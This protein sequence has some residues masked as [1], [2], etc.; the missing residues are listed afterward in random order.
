M[1][2]H[3]AV[4]PSILETDAATVLKRIG[5]LPARCSLVEIR[6]DSLSSDDL[7][8][9]VARCGRDAVVTIRTKQEGGSFIGSES[10]RLDLLMAGLHT[11]A[12]YVD[13]P[14]DSP[15]AVQGLVPRER[16]ILS[17]HGNHREHGPLSTILS[18]MTSIGAALYKMVPLAMGVECLQEI[19]EFL[20]EVP[21]GG[22][23]VICF[24]A[25]RY[26]A[27]SRILAPSWGSR[28]TF[29]F[30]PGGRPTAEGQFPAADLL[31]IYNVPAIGGQ[32][33]IFGLL[34]RDLAGSPSPAM[35]NAA[36]RDLG[37]DARYLPM[38]V[39]S[40]RDFELLSDPDG[41]VGAEGFGVTMPFKGEAAARCT[42]LD[43]WSTAA[44]AVN[45]LV[46]A[47]DGWH[48]RNSDAMAI[49]MLVGS[50]LSPRNRRVL[51][52]GAGGIARGATVVLRDA[53]AL[54][55]MVGR[56]P[57]R[58]RQVAGELGVESVPDW[59]DRFPADILV[60]A[61]PAGRDG[62]DWPDACRLPAKLVL[63]APYSRTETDLVRKARKA[64]L[65]VI[66]GKDLILA[67]AVSQFNLLTGRQPMREVM[68]AAMG[69][70]FERDPA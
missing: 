7:S 58:V 63:D 24:A 53:G 35:H 59:P 1:P 6:A 8:R 11:G 43:P 61:T 20:K 4:V 10:E 51:V 13:L 14:I 2:D 62:Q 3:I 45:T 47:A 17:W 39:D 38:A 48:G 44:G 50:V 41:P 33:R 36:F 57:D 56:N 40:M 22:P 69:R 30:P 67:Q 55:T 31:D 18:R 54:V 19:R 68:A 9:V 65:A 5:R 64:G 66:S 23:A 70:W 32:T 26:G 37:M 34:G 15:A 52:Y 12:A 16:L 27:Q 28:W 60:N 25:G 42:E 46:Q 21:P 29:G 49:R